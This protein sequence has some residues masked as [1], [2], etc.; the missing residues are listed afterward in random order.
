MSDSLEIE[1]PCC[2]ALIVVDRASGEVLLHKAKEKKFSR[3]LEEMVSEIDRQ[4]LD[5]EQLFEKGLE[6]QKNR[7]DLLEK[8]FREAMQR[9]DKDDDEPRLNPLDLD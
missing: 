9:V 7:Q 3:S 8:R 5:R 2:E 4:K 6:G 1:C